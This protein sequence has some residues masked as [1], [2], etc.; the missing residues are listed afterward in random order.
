MVHMSK[1]FIEVGA[2]SYNTLAPLLNAG[3]RGIFVE[4]TT[5]YSNT[6]RDNLASNYANKAWSLANVAIG[7]TNRTELMNICLPEGGNLDY[8]RGVS[9]L[10][11]YADISWH[12]TWDDKFSKAQNWDLEVVNV[13]TLDELID[14]YEVTNIDYLKLDVEGSEPEIMKAYS[15]KIKPTFFSVEVISNREEIVSIL[16]SQ[17]Y[18]ISSDFNNPEN[19]LA[20]V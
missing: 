20:I 16:K 14:R 11:R 5:I 6:L 10:K 8:A 12:H 3:W 1:V 4:P 19:L 15:W 7:N 18:Y 13:I 2:C 9:H 17:G